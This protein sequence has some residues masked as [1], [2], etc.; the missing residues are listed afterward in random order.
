MEKC[1]VHGRVSMEV[2]HLIDVNKELQKYIRPGGHYKLIRYAVVD[3]DVP[4]CA[5][6][7]DWY[8][9]PELRYVKDCDIKGYRKRR[10]Q[11]WLSE[12]LPIH[13]DERFD[14]Y[15]VRCHVEALKELTLMNQKYEEYQNKFPHIVDK[16]VAILHFGMLFKRKNMG[17]SCD[18]TESK[19]IIK[20]LREQCEMLY[21][22][23][24]IIFFEES[25]EKRDLTM[26]PKQHWILHPRNLCGDSPI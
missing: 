8:Y 14:R 16:W 13:E 20:L 26:V 22:R 2:E 21:F 10:I 5:E 7:V 17:K 9:D 3:E 15:L 11:R 6:Y 18:V 24:K 4:V 23:T 25:E 19:L 1:M 12:V